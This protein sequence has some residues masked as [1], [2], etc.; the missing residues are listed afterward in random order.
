MEIEHVRAIV[1]EQFLAERENQEKKWGSQINHTDDYW[2][3]I[4]AEEFG[5]VA[6]EVYEKNTKNLYDE[7]IQCGAVCMAWAEAIQ[8]R[9]M[10]RRVEKGDDLL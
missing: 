5:E 9:N 3:V 10:K 4:L 1:T 8:K 6:R 2:T 7:L